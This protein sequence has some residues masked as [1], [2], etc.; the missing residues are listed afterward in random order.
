M[1]RLGRVSKGARELGAQKRTKSE[2]G[3][4]RRNE[5]KKFFKFFP[6]SVEKVVIFLIVYLL[7]N[8]E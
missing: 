6:T 4:K 7:R 8:A 3:K 2:K 5:T 1:V